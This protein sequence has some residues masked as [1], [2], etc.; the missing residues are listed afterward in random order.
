MTPWRWQPGA[1]TYRRWYIINSVSQSTVR[2]TEKKLFSTILYLHVASNIY[3]FRL[4]LFNIHSLTG[5]YTFHFNFTKFCPYVVDTAF[6]NLFH[7]SIEHHNLT[8]FIRSLFL[9]SHAFMV[10]VG[11]NNF[12]GI[13]PEPLY[14]ALNGGDRRSLRNPGI[15]SAFYTALAAI[16][17]VPLQ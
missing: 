15:Y 5:T 8:H 13:N 11:T 7:T 10:R 16:R 17:I 1:E 14:V 3:Y 9:F 2:I 12:I 4:I 6:K